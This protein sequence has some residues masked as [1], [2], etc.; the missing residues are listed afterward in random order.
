[1]N[2]VQLQETLDALIAAWE[3]E[4]VEFKQARDGFSTNDIGKYFS[5]LS[6]EAN[7]RGIEKAWLVFG[8]DNNSRTVV[9]TD[10]RSNAERL[11]SLKMQIAG[12]T[13]PSITFRN[14]YE[15]QSSA[16][17][18]VLFEIPPAPQGMPIAWKGHYYARAGESLTAL[19]I[20][21]Q[22]EMRQQ[23]M[24]TDWSAQIVPNAPIAALD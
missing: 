1:M 23:T 6:N 3:S 21:K 5:A 9:G 10:Y 19:H 17:R 4:V 7:L 2:E 8:V 24:A 11:Q 14:I 15:L 18:V 20:D 22:D 12:N 13:E 16:G